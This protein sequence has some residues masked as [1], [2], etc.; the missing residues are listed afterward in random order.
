MKNMRL[1][2]AVLLVVAMPLAAQTEWRDLK[3]QDKLT[4]LEC[5]GESY[6]KNGSDYA[7]GQYVEDFIVVNLGGIW[8]P[9]TGE[10]FESTK[11]TDIEHIVARSEAHWSGLCFADRRTRR[12]FSSDLL[13]LTLS[14]PNLNRNEKKH[15]D[16]AEWTPRT[17]RCWFAEA[18]LAVKIK[19]DLS[20]DCNE[21]K[22]LERML[23]E[24]CGLNERQPRCSP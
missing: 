21:A 22:A 8:S 12:A 4:P 6:S 18:V 5:D 7:Y 1:T 24:N 2:L 15:Y 3:I 14:D 19:Y 13:N 23:H 16:A 10:I 11:E 17:N 20:V 9:Y